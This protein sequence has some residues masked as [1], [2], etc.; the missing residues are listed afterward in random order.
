MGCGSINIRRHITASQMNSML[1]MIYFI[2]DMIPQTTTKSIEQVSKKNKGLLYCYS[3]S[4]IANNAIGFHSFFSLLEL[5]LQGVV[6][7]LVR[8]QTRQIRFP[9]V[10][11]HL[12]IY[13]CIY[14][15]IYI[16]IHLLNEFDFEDSSAQFL[17]ISLNYILTPSSRYDC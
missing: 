15:S 2:F 1:T 11:L 7:S 8:S 6:G 9:W 5:S 13:T 17:P 3:N 4:H 12:N 14:T 16:Q 10:N